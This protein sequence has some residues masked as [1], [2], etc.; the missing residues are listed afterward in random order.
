M[1]GELEQEI[2]EMRAVVVRTGGNKVQKLESEKSGILLD[3][4]DIQ[5]QLTAANVEL[6]KWFYIDRL[7]II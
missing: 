2:L 5:D 4:K 1:I 3:M 7:F 6:S